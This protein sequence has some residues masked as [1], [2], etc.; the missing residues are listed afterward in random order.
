MPL[1]YEVLE[2]LS[3]ELIK[4]FLHLKVHFARFFQ[5]SSQSIDKTFEAEKK[6]KDELGDVF[7]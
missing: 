6:M 1:L 7:A 2:P 4:L 3:Q 5:F